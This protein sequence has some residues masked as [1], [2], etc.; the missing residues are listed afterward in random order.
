MVNLKKR[1]ERLGMNLKN[2]RIESDTVKG[3]VMGI[4][5]RELKVCSVYSCRR[6]IFS[7]R[8]SKRELKE[9]MFKAAFVSEIPRISKRELK[10]LKP[11]YEACYGFAKLIIEMVLNHFG[12]SLAHR[13]P[14]SSTGVQS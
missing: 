11:R 6:R 3:D 2:E 8:I 13:F 10:V 14:R 5:K 9:I 4:S 12:L 1:I 7:W